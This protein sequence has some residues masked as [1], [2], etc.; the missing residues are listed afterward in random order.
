MFA[1]FGPPRNQIKDQVKSTGSKFSD[2]STSW[3]IY[4][5][6]NSGVKLYTVKDEDNYLKQMRVS[7]LLL[8]L[9]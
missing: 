5:W 9:I 6:L 3:F 7:F 4:V 8:T 1:S 2:D